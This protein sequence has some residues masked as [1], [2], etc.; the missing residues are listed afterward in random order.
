MDCLQDLLELDSEV[1]RINIPRESAPFL[2]VLPLPDIPEEHLE[3]GLNAPP[4][5]PLK[6]PHAFVKE[7]RW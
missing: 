6:Y 2:S 7:E 1:N 3:D 5:T 4:V